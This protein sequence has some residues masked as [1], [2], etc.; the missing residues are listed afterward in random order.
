[1][2]N[3]LDDALLASLASIKIYVLIL[4]SIAILVGKAVALA[5]LAVTA[6]TLG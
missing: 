4:H 1:M 2:S 5:V 6:M 3:M